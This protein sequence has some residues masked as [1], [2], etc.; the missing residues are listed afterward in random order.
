VTQKENVDMHRTKKAR[1][2]AVLAAG[3]LG[4]SLAGSVFAAK[5]S[6]SAPRAAG[7]GK[8]INYIASVEGVTP[9]V[10]KQELKQGKTLLQIAGSKYASADALA[11]ALL[12]PVQT[13]L[14]TAVTNHRLTLAQEK[15]LYDQLHARVATLV[16]TPH[17]LRQLRSALQRG[18]AGGRAEGIRSG[19]VQTMVTTCGI[20]AA[21]LRTVFKTGGKTPLAICQGG[22]KAPVTQKGLVSA[23]MSAIQTRLEARAKAL[24]LT[25][26]QALEQQI[27]ARIEA[28]LNVWVTT[29]IPAGGSHS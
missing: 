21:D 16:V 14:E 29:P 22:T 6:P 15:T 25:L 4:L 12:A 8:V 2:G 3:V 11:T 26:N 1:M 28:G 19:L 18:P 17:P 5:S 7:H 23:L 10:L 20:T 13:R 24:G 27:L 9:A